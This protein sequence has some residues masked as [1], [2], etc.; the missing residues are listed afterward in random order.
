M[1]APFLVGL[2]L[3][4]GTQAADARHYRFHYR[5]WGHA[6]RY[7]GT[8][9]L[10]D[11]GPNALPG[12]SQSRP[13]MRVL[14]RP[15][16]PPDWHLQ[17]V[18]PEHNGRR[19]RSPDGVASLVFYASPAS[20]ESASEH[21]KSIAFVDGEDVLKLAGTP[22]ELV[23][24]GTKN[25]RMFVRKARLACGG[26][27][28]HHVAIEFPI[29]ARREYARVAEQALAALN[30]ADDDGCAAPVAT[31][32]PA[33]ATQQTIGQTPSRPSGSN[34]APAVAPASPFGSDPGDP[35]SR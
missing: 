8:M 29:I 5:Y 2:L 17:P 19:Y 3:L 13:G 34:E 1:R 33:D 6:L 10:R 27:D 4:L 20:R 32:E 35:K 7:G 16:P 26:H 18:D 24:T 9:A 21:F 28:W 31:N 25:E 12:P 11:P 23:V 30:L 22:G 15:F 14:G